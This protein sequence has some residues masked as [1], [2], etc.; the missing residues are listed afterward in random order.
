MNGGVL[1]VGVPSASAADLAS[2]SMLCLLNACSRMVLGPAVQAKI[3]SC[4]VLLC[5]TLERLH[6]LCDTVQHGG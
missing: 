5:F 2:Q 6:V 3:I 4:F 1:I